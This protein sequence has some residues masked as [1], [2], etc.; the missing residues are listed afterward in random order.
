MTR[1]PSLPHSAI[2]DAYALALGCILVVLGL[3]L[4]HAAGLVTGGIAGVALLLSYAVPLPSGVLFTLLNLPFFWL[5]WRAMGR[6]FTL[7]T[8][9]VG[10]GVA[11]LGTVTRYG[12]SIAYINPAFAALAGGSVIGFGALALARHHAGIGG[13]GVVTLWLQQRRGWNAGRTQIAI[14]A[15]IL[16]VSLVALP[17]ERV[18]WSALSAAAISGIL[19]AWHRP[20]RYTGY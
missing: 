4:L 11:A 7:R 16:L 3:A 12:L 5:A 1:P 9:L 15:V 14:D 8:A 6:R 10:I 13:T 20:G 18:A 2:E 19:I 17:L